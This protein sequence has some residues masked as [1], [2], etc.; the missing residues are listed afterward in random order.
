MLHLMFYQALEIMI[1]AGIERFIEK[2]KK[3]AKKIAERLGL[4]LFGMAEST[5]VVLLCWLFG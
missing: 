2:D 3:T 5:L 1:F 4:V